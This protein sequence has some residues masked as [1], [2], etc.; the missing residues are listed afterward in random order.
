MARGRPTSGAKLVNT[1]EGSP[2]ARARVRL[3]LETLSGAIS[4]PEACAELGLSEARF[5]E[6]RR[7]LLGATVQAAEGR[8]AGRPPQAAQEA[9]ALQARNQELERRLHELR[10]QNEAL[11][12]RAELAL[13]LPHLLRPRGPEKKTRPRRPRGDTSGT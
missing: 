3:V 11:Q 8:P 10:L 7:E 6:L 4:I 9:A 1:I 5:H 12:I 13:A 2:E